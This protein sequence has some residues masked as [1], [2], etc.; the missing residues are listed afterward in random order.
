MR[1]LK[2]KRD[3]L[4]GELHGLM[5]GLARREKVEKELMEIYKEWEVALAAAGYSAV[6]SA[7]MPI[8]KIK[9]EISSI[10]IMGLV[11]PKI[12]ITEKP[13]IDSIQDISI[14]KAAERLQA[15]IDE[16]L[17]VA[18]IEASIE[19]IAYELMATN[20]KVNAL[21]KVVIPAYVE[22]IR[23]IEDLLFDEDLEDFARIKHFR[24]AAG[25]ERT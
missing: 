18:Q 21:E 10:S 12:R 24:D 11:V 20:R 22:Q 9:T 19:R 3:R 6:F 25:R 13:Q 17:Y 15:L 23:Y 1:I 14:Y 7:A 5:G 16:L 8:S 4:A 2:M